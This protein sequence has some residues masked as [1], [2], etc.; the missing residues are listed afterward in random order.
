MAVSAIFVR[1]FFVFAVVSVQ[2]RCHAFKKWY[3]VGPFVTGKTEVDAD[4][5][6]SF[7]HVSSNRNQSC[8]R[9]LILRRAKG[10]PKTFFSE[11]AT[12]GYV[13]LNKLPCSPS[14]GPGTCQLVIQFPLPHANIDF[15]FLYSGLNKIGIISFQGWATTSFTVA[16]DGW[17]E[18][19]LNPLHLFFLNGQLYAAD[20]YSTSTAPNVMWLRS[21]TRHTL[22]VRIRAK[23]QLTFHAAIKKVPGDSVL[24]LAS[25]REEVADIVEG[26]LPFN[27]PTYLQLPLSNMG[28]SWISQLTPVITSVVIGDRKVSSPTVTVSRGGLRGNNRLNQWD[29]LPPAHTQ[30]FPFAVALEGREG[31]WKSPGLQRTGDACLRFRVTLCCVVLCCAVLCCAVLC[32]AVLCCSCRHY[33]ARSCV[34]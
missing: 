19:H 3:F 4:P 15:N 25:S 11:L 13:S 7:R 32:C 30:L 9:S 18:F 21:E 8:T 2:Y 14:S 6:E 33:C 28:G 23:G 10:C 16:V 27:Q 20:I 34:L 17:Y 29:Q 22:D 1:A 26:K 24:R 31:W 12:A 5:L